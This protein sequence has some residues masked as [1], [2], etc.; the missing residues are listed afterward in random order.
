MDIGLPRGTGD[1]G[2][3]HAVATT[4]PE[5]LKSFRPSLVLY[6]AG[7][8]PHKVSGLLVP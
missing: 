3:L 7:V 6:D 5:L 2:Y 8:D 4:L 1:E